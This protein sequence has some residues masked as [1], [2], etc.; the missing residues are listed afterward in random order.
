MVSGKIVNSGTGCTNGVHIVSR[1]KDMRGSV[2]HWLHILD[3]SKTIQI[4]HLHIEKNDVWLKFIDLLD[5]AAYPPVASPT[6][7]MPSYSAR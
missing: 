6:T 1:D 5:R 3:D 7:S 2:V 4:R